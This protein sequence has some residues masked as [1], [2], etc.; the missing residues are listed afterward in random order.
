MSLGIAIYPS[1]MTMTAMKTY[2]KQA[3]DLG[4]RRIFTSMLEVADN[5]Q[6]TLDKYQEIIHYGNQLYMETTID[7]SPVLFDKLNI[8]YQDLALFDQIG[9]KAIRLD[10]GFTGMEEAR[11][12]QN[13]YGIKIELNI[14]RGQHYIDLIQDFSPNAA[15]IMGSHNFYPQ[16]FT[17]LDSQYFIATA[18]QYKKYHLTTAAFV[19]TASGAVG[20]WP[21]SNL[22]VSA[23][24]QRMM[25]ISTQVRWLKMLGVIDDILIAS[26]LVDIED[27]KAVASA[28][29]E[30]LP[31][32]TVTFNDNATTLEKQIILESTHMYR[33]D[34]SGYMIRSTMTRIV[35]RNQLNE[36]RQTNDIDIGDITVGNSNA[37]QYQNETQIALKTRPNI[38][39]QHNVVGR[40]RPSDL[41][42]LQQLKPWQSFRLH[43][44]TDS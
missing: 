13:P 5:P 31:S 3:A 40:I 27:L 9:A 15:A 4:Y 25:P 43:T 38:G 24:I 6:E 12:T 34:Y 33:G 22:M 18:Q 16:S 1:K 28:Y 2:V 10:E 7:I 20:P 23:E 19:D 39:Q 14:S 35:Y 26:S 42:L 37:G 32:L 11:M 21:N 30:P 36:P 29:F 44:I 17:G 41:P 8:S